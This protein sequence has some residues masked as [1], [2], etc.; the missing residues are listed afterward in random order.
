[1]AAAMPP[2]VD[3]AQPA[4]EPATSLARVRPPIVGPLGFGAALA[5]PAIRGPRDHTGQ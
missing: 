1:M 5:V 2:I 3:S 4:N